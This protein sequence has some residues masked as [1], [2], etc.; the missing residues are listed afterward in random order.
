MNP[1]Y[2]IAC[3]ATWIFVFVYE[4]LL[5]GVILQPL[6]METPDLWRTQADMCNHFQWLVLGQIIFV[7][8]FGYIFTKGYEGLGIAEGARYGWWIGLLLAAPNLVMYAV[9]PLPP[10]LVIGWSVGGLIEGTLAGMVLAAIY[11]PVRAR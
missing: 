11:R 2:I 9:Q 7:F 6:Y 8:L 10:L 1:R 4:W 5:H 3:I